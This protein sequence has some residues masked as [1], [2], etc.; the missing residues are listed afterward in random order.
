MV[1]M[2]EPIIEILPLTKGQTLFRQGDPATAAYILNSGAIA[3][4]R[5]V[6]GKRIPVARV[7][8]GEFFGEMAIIDG[9]PR[10]NSAMALDDCTLSLV[11]KDMIEEKLAATDALI[12]SVLHMLT[13]SLRMVHE[14]YSPKGRNI[15]DAVREM[16]EQAQSVA[17]SMA[18]GSPAL[19]KD[20]ADALKKLTVLSEAIMGL[21]EGA[22]ELDRRTPALPSA[23]DL[24]G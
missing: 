14:T 16:K 22:P 9:R 5:E 4:F 8:K 1:A 13:N 20:G 19:Q 15:L 12:R 24:A 17:A 3:I 2:D 10:R 18:A 7:K 11:S 6:D 23:R 21:I